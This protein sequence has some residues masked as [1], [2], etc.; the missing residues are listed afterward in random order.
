MSG[1]D[2]TGPG[3]GIVLSKD[4][5]VNNTLIGPYDTTDNVNVYLK[6]TLGATVTPVSSVLVGN[7]LT[8]TANIPTPS[9]VLLKFPIASQTVSY[10]TGDTGWRF[11]NGWYNYNPPAYPLKKA[12]LDDTAGLNGFFTLKTALTV[13][14]ISSK[15]RFVDINGQQTFSIAGNANEVVIDKLTGLM[16]T[17]NT[18]TNGQNWNT[19][20]DNA[21]AYSIALNS[22]TYSNW[23]LIGLNDWYSM[24]G[25][26]GGFGTFTDPVSG[27]TLISFST[28]LNRYVRLA[29]SID[30]SNSWSWNIAF[31]SFGNGYS[32]ANTDTARSV[33]VHDATNLIS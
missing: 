7:D 32:K 21:V 6:D 8:I 15:V 22:V 28:G 29:D 11:Q 14:G 19:I 33:Y 2:I 10:R 18:S 27:I 17:R 26:M 20:I 4:I 16:F 9:G 1:I 3:A 24:F 31:N 30:A 23:Y 25:V 12:E 5:F 13:G